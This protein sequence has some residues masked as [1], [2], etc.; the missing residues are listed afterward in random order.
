MA[1]IRINALATTAAST[2]SDD[3]IAIDGSANG[4]RKLNAYSPTFG[5]D[6]TVSGTENIAGPI[7][8]TANTSQAAG[9]IARNSYYGL[10]LFGIVGGPFDFG[11]VNKNGDEV[12]V[13]PT[14][15]VN[16]TL[17]GNL[18][19]SGTGSHVF[20]TVNTVTLAGGT[21]TA[22]KGIVVSG[23][24]GSGLTAEFSGATGVNVRF[25]KTDATAQTWQLYG[26]GNFFG[27]ED[28]TG[29]LVPFKIAKATGNVGIGTTSPNTKLSVAHVASSGTSIGV[30]HASNNAQLLSIGW[31]DSTDFTFINTSNGS[32]PLALQNTGG[33][34]LVGAT[35]DGG[36]KLQVNGSAKFSDATAEDQFNFY[37]TA[38]SPAY[39]SLLRLRQVNTSSNAAST[40]LIY[41]D[42]ENGGSAG[43]KFAV[44]E[45]GKVK[46]PALPTSSAGLSAGDLW[47]DSGTLKIA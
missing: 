24:P 34:V 30:Q 38:T 3:Y 11:L 8:F 45:S 37:N 28:V 7:Q 27:V 13:V 18:T 43:L 23:A 22:N 21:M 9:S 25:N 35:T 26:D 47:N 6:L 12:L 41:A 16:A 4:T 10:T 33:N 15:T 36:Q 14:G 31:N 19:A 29:N 32:R 46:M 39:S 40:Y 20:G 42:V 5:G 17:A 2:A 44:T 1:D